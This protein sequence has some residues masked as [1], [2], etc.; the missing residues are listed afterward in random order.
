MRLYVLYG[1][2]KRVVFV[3]VSGFIIENTVMFVMGTS[4]GQ[5]LIASDI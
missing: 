1:R 5:S 2:S 3:V 4:R